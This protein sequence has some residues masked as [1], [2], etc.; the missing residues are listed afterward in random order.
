V[1][2]ECKSDYPRAPKALRKALDRAEDLIH[3]S[4]KVG[5]IIAHS[6]RLGTVAKKAGPFRHGDTFAVIS[7]MARCHAEPCGLQQCI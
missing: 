3:Y 7:G 5:T 1:K 4:C 6:A 2:E